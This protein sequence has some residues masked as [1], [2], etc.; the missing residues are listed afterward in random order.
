MKKFDHTKK[1]QFTIEVPSD[2]L[3]FLDFKLKFDKE[4]K[5]ISADVFAKDTDSF[6]YVLPST[7]FH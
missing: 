2:T 7:C 3:E 5:Q 1:I 6:T 4:T